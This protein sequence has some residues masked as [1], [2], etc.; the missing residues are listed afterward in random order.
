MGIIL[1]VHVYV[2]HARR[3]SLQVPE[4]TY[5]FLNLYEQHGIIIIVHHFL[6]D[7]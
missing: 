3:S 7:Q 1:Y 5:N 6:N 2:Y 4:I